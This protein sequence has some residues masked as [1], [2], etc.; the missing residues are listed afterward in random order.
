[1][2]SKVKGVRPSPDD[3]P[4]SQPE[5]LEKLERLRALAVKRS[6][7]SEYLKAIGSEFV[8]RFD[9]N[10]GGLIGSLRVAIAQLMEPGPA[11]LVLRQKGLNASDL[12]CRHLGILHVF[13]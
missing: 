4:D 9:G 10:M 8:V 6:Q 12:S 3:V 11:F 7:Q 1:M 2:L 13:R 5:A